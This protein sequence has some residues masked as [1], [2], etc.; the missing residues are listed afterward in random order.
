[1]TGY[2][3]PRR[4][5]RYKFSAQAEIIV[6]GSG[7]KQLCRVKEL[8]LHGCFLDCPEPL[9]PKTHILLKIY[10]GHDYFEATANV[11][12]SHPALGMGI[13]FRDVRPAFA[14]VLRSWLLK[15]MNDTGAV[16]GGS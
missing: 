6:D 13:G 14:E 7:A 11:I 2:D 3:Q 15:A 10:E 1:M 5:P 4:T 8:S 12:F 9:S 16:L